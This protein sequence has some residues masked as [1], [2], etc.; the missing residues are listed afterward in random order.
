MKLGR[1]VVDTHVHPQRFAAGRDLGGDRSPGRQWETLSHTIG[2][3]EAYDNSARLL[4]DMECYGVDMCVL[5]P[6]FGM[7]NELNAKIVAD[8]PERFVAVCNVH[9]YQE[10]VR[11][12]EEQWSIEG[13]CAELDRLLG[14]GRFVGVGEESPY[15]PFPRDPRRPVTREQATH[16]MFAIMEVAA[17][18]GVS[19]RLH[20]GCPMGYDTGYSTGALGPFNLNPMWAHDLASAFPQVP[21]VFDHGGVQGWWSERL[22]EDC[23]HVAASHDNVY[24][25]TGL[26]WSELYERA[27]A[28]PNV[29]A[30]K[31]MWGTDWGA[32]IDFH[33]QPGRYPPSYAV[34]VRSRG[35]TTHQ[36]DYW[37]WSLRELSR[38]RLPQDD[39][40]LILGGNAARVFKL[41]LPHTRLFRPP[42]TG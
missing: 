23:L 30:D 2:R 13:V 29:G 24:L 38:L 17:R 16:N 32:S 19:V 42:R 41:P 1:F 14:S 18:H 6:A 28:D 5:L 8:H 7:S 40:N 33:Y 27:L 15:M 21:I 36:T 26:W 10:R 9:E 37:G 34:Q 25:E 11:R 35:I 12:G 31:L 39:L 22:Q 20:T 3:L 4:Y